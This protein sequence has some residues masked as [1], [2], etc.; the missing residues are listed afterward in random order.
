MKIRPDH[1]AS[2]RNAIKPL[3]TAFHRSRYAAAGLS[4]RRYRWDLLH[5][6]GLKIG[7][8]KGMG[9]LPLYGYLNDDH[10][11]TAL[12]HLVQPLDRSAA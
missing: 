11:D 4:D 8:G 12:R 1:L 6:S 5:H 2:I 7:D 10:I 3:D 9:G